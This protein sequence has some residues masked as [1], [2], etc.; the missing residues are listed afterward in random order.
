M[1]FVVYLLYNDKEIFFEP[2]GVQ[3]ESNGKHLYFKCCSE[4]RAIKLREFI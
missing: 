2:Q 1:W 3:V 4:E